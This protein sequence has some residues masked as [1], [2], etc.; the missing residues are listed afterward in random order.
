MKHRLIQDEVIIE[1]SSRAD[2]YL[3]HRVVCDGPFWRAVV[4]AAHG[5]ERLGEWDAYHLAEDC[6]EEEGGAQAY[7]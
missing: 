5:P 4:S 1:L 2:L 3:M 7:A 6:W